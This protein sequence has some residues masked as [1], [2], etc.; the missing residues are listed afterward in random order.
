MTKITRKAH[1]EVQ[2]GGGVLR[3]LLHV[4]PVALLLTLRG[5]AP[6]SHNARTTNVL[7]SMTS[8]DVSTFVA[9]CM[10]KYKCAPIIIPIGSNEP[11]HGDRQTLG[12]DSLIAKRIAYDVAKKS[13]IVVGPTIDVGISSKKIGG[14][15]CISL[16]KS[17]LT[18]L[19]YDMAWS[20]KI[21]S[22][23]TH[24]FFVNGHSD[25]VMPMKGVEEMLETLPPP[26][27]FFEDDLTCSC[28]CHVTRPQLAYSCYYASKHSRRIARSLFGEKFGRQVGKWPSV[29]EE[30]AI[31]DYLQAHPLHLAAGCECE[32][33]GE[34]IYQT[35]VDET[36]KDFVRFIKSA[37]MDSKLNT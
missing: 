28:K 18:T 33:E 29:I 27:E 25:N 16:R 32:R 6:F 1:G 14:P 19:V 9:D 21:S 2:G 7:S 26:D 3:R 34:V 10:E 5:V 13:N 20:L 8:D 36:T 31:M 17:T 22:G 4:I 30:T 12:T 23:F 24:L 11:H 15:G 35:A 37:L